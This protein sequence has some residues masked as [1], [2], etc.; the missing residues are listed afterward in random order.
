MP[1]FRTRRWGWISSPVWW[2]S[3]PENASSSRSGIPR[4]KRGSG[5][6]A[7]SAR[8]QWEGL[9]GFPDPRGEEDFLVPVAALSKGSEALRVS[10]QAHLQLAGNSVQGKMHPVSQ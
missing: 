6:T 4:V 5:G 1:R 9:L 3:N 2:R 7:D 10:A 8:E